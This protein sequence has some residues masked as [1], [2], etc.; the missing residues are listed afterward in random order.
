MRWEKN[1]GNSIVI[2]LFIL[3]IFFGNN[4]DSALLNSLSIQK[5]TFKVG[6]IVNIV[7]TGDI[8]NNDLTITSES[9][10]FRFLGDLET[11]VVFIPTEPGTYNVQLRDQNNVLQDEITFT[12]IPIK[13]IIG[14]WL[15]VKNSDQIELQASLEVID[16]ISNFRYKDDFEE[17]VYDA[18]RT[19]CIS[20]KYITSGLV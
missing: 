2:M 19:I 12:I 1:T 5:T 20:N 6:E 9:S 8:T 14:D 7:L 17:G 4:V 11:N 18:Y 3:L 15:T 10:S 13:K 16:K